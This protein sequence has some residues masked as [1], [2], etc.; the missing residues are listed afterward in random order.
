MSEL[1]AKVDSESRASAEAALYAS[2]PRV[3]VIDRA[4]GVELVVLYKLIKGGIEFAL[5]AV[6]MAG[7]IFGFAHHLQELTAQLRTHV[8]RAWAV[9]SAEW[10]MNSTTP[11]HLHLAAIALFLDGLLTGFEAWAL[12]RGH[13][14]GPWLVVVASG[15]LLPWEV[16]ELIHYRRV[17]RLLVFLVNLAI[18]V[19]LTLHALRERRHRRQLAER[20]RAA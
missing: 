15:S 16:V 5:L 11:T 12:R 20:K 19:Y 3:E 18:V 6:L 10:L 1:L 2:A 9:A 8:T 13:W 7:L 4:T 17:G 14:W